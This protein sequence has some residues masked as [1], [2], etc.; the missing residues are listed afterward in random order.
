[1][2]KVLTTIL[3]ISI[4]VIASGAQVDA[5]SEVAEPSQFELGEDPN[6]DQRL[7]KNNQSIPFEEIFKKYDDSVVSIILPQEAGTGTGFLLAKEGRLLHVVTPAHVISGY[8]T[9]PV[10]VAFPDG[11]TY[12]AKVLG[13]D[14]RLDIALLQIRSNS[15]EDPF[16]PVTLG[17]SS[18]ILVGEEVLAI[19]NPSLAARSIP[20]FAMRGIVG[21]AGVEVGGTTNVPGVIGAIV[22]DFAVAGGSSGSPLFDHKGEAIGMVTQGEDPYTT[23]SVPS[24]IIRK[25]ADSLADTGVYEYPWIGMTPVTLTTSLVSQYGLPEGTKGIY[26]DT[27]ARDGPAHKAGLTAAIL[28]EFGEVELGDVITAIDGNP[29]TTG[30]QFNL[31]VEEKTSVGDTVLLSVYKNGTMQEIPVTIE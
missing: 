3:G 4:I 24:N 26:I 19:G 16:E 13:S 29:I 14:P 18:E 10:D 31:F 11:S 5:T 6:F 23:Y 9:E 27:I 25:V 15:T 12:A 1:L 17:N 28:N 22:T 2:L 20:N 30:D 21:A 7:T 8:E